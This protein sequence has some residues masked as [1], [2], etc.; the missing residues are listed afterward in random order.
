MPLPAARDEALYLSRLVRVL[1][2]EWVEEPGRAIATERLSVREVAPDELKSSD[3]A[4]RFA[5]LGQHPGQVM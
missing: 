2:L 4:V 5:S 3:G 1:Q